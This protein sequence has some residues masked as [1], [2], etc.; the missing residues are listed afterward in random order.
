MGIS[1][2]SSMKTFMI[3]NQKHIVGCVELN[4]VDAW[5]QT[6]IGVAHVGMTRLDTYSRRS[7]HR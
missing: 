1:K 7:G 6:E 4:E 2:R 3:A 5:F